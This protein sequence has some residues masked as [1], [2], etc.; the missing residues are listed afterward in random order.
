MSS[1]KEKWQKFKRYLSGSAVEGETYKETHVEDLPHM[2]DA[3]GALIAVSSGKHELS[4]AVS[5]KY[6][7]QPGKGQEK[8]E[9]VIN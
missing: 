6:G 5:A 1:L 3:D 4:P 7:I 8:I 2:V 9:D